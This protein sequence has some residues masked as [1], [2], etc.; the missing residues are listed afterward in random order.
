MLLPGPGE[1]HVVGGSL[2]CPTLKTRRWTL[3]A[4]PEAVYLSTV[5]AQ[6][7]LLDTWRSSC[8]PSSWQDEVQHNPAAELASK[9]PMLFWRFTLLA[10]DTPLEVMFAHS[11]WLHR[12]LR[13]Q[14]PHALLSACALFAQDMPQD[15]ISASSPGLLDGLSLTLCARA[16]RLCDPTNATGAGGPSRRALNADCAHKQPLTTEPGCAL[17]ADCAQRRLCTSRKRL[18][19]STGWHKRKSKREK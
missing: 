12:G 1:A 18:G 10:R 15:V 2:K 5:Q 3:S 16:V 17:N 14:D 6:T 11:P 4:V 13:K 19:E 9:T 7:I 8:V